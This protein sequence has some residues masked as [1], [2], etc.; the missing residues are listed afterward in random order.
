M[1]CKEFK[2][3]LKRMKNEDSTLLSDDN[4]KHTLIKQI[5]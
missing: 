5:N 3:D 1:M 4:S 2:E